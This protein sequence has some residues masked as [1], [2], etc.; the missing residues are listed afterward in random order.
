MRIPPLRFWFWLLVLAPVVLT[1][2][3]S[4]W[5]AAGADRLNAWCQKIWREAYGE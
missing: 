5:V 2:I 1:G 4:A 3:A